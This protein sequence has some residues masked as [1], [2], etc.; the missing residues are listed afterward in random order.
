MGFQPLPARGGTVPVKGQGPPKR[1]RVVVLPTGR[2][3]KFQT[4]QVPQKGN[5]GC[6]TFTGLLRQGR[7]HEA[8]SQAGGDP[9]A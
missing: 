9:K 8:H 6:K 3:L 4:F 7:P 5:F 1:C 2:S